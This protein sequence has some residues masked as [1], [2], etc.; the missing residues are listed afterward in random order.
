MSD[1]PQHQAA[2]L[3]SIYMYRMVQ[4]TKVRWKFEVDNQMVIVR[5]G[6]AEMQ[7]P[8]TRKGASLPGPHA[9]NVPPNAID[10]Y[11]K[12]LDERGIKYSMTETGQVVINT[13]PNSEKTIMQFLDLNAPCPEGFEAIREQFKKE[14][15]QAGGAACPSCQL[16]TLQRK[17]REIL[18]S[19]ITDV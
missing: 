18:K 10:Q 19:K 4:E 8:A 15:E 12:V 2:P 11:K 17:Y 7:E 5:E 9:V 14:Y 3:R 6:P 1:I 16:N 13:I